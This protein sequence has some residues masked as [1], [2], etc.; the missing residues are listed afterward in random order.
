MNMCVQMIILIQL[1]RR[2]RG[3]R[4]CLS[5]R[6]SW[7]AGVGLA[8]WRYVQAQGCL[9][10]W[11]VCIKQTVFC[12]H[13]VNLTDVAVSERNACKFSKALML[14]RGS[15]STAVLC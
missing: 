5:K 10:H 12:S 13:E 9:Y 7:S 11:L 2:Y 1:R 14:V 4:C 3:A 8:W 6:H 15:R